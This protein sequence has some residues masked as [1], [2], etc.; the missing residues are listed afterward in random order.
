MKKNKEIVLFG[1]SGHAFVAAEVI[2]KAGYT[3]MGYL[4]KQEQ[5]LNPYGLKY[6]GFEEDASLM[7]SLYNYAFFP[8]IG[9]N[10]IRRKVFETFIAQGFEFITAIHPKANIASM[11]M[12]GQGSL[13]CQG[14]NINPLV[15]MGTGVIINTGAVVEHE[16]EIGDFSH[17]APGA[18]LAGNVEV[19]YNTFIG[20]NAVVKQGVRIGNN[21]VVGAGA[22]VL[23]D[24]DDNKIYFGNPAKIHL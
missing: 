18:V 12:I 10:N 13:V 5:D 6:L 9:D 4:D 8:S 17:I 19:G 24:L 11:V 21:V 22:V 3:L 1:Y 15:E 14:A 23:H 20:A 16:C 7:N 2:V